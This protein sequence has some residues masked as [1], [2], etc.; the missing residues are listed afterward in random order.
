MKKSIAFTITAVI[1][2]ATFFVVYMRSARRTAK[3]LEQLSTDMVVIPGRDYMLCKYEVSQALW[4]AVMGENPSCANGEQFPVEFVSWDDCQ[5]FLKKL[6]AMSAVA[7]SGR[8]YRLPTADE[9]EYACR[10]GATDKYGALGNSTEVS[11][12]TCRD[13]KWFTGNLENGSHPVGQKEPN[14]I[15]LYDMHDNVCEWCQEVP[16]ETS[17][18]AQRNPHGRIYCGGSWQSPAW[19]CFSTFRRWGV[20]DLREDFLG[21]RLACDIVK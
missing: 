7:A 6:N 2:A 5:V 16:E 13:S 1:I 12:D 10:M 9:W 21:L 8:I 19:F 4:A 14:A 20:Q 15:G 17:Q 3:L 18:E 11:D